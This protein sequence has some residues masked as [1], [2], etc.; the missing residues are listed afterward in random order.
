MTL[1]VTWFDFIYFFL[2]VWAIKKTYVDV[3]FYVSTSLKILEE[4][5]HVALF[6]FKH[7]GGSQCIPPSL[8]TSH[9]WPLSVSES[10]P[11]VSM[12]G[13]A[14]DKEWRA[15]DFQKATSTTLESLKASMS[16]VGPQPRDKVNGVSQKWMQEVKFIDGNN[17]LI[18][19]LGCRGWR[20]QGQCL[21]QFVLL[22]KCWMWAGLLLWRQR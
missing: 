8:H 4:I 9:R 5:K 20:V 7:V 15:L 21:H 11:I 3:L 1:R 19:V 12:A 13:C 2:L 14:S 16:C 18:M 17:S 10:T 6:L 22:V